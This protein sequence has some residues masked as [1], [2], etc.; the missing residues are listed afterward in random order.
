M[1]ASELP[2]RITLYGGGPGFGLPEVSPY[3][4]KT[5]VQLRMAGL[6]FTKTRADLESVPKHKM[7]YLDDDG[8]VADSTFIRAH[9]ER[10]YG[11]D[12]DRGL[13]QRQRAEA[14]AI[15]RMLED[16]LAWT[17][18]HGR[19][20]QPENF[21]KGPARFFDGA[22]EAIREKLRADVLDRVRTSFYSQGTGR[23]AQE[24]I[25]ALGARSLAALSVLLGDKPYLFGDVVTGTDATAFAV[26]AC[27]LTPFFDT[28]LR[29]EAE[30]YENL[31]AY[32]ARMMA[33]FY[34]DFAW[35]ST[36]VELAA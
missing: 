4:T 5:E 33:L 28:G 36:P 9:I 24:E 10:K 15:E 34:P 32:T 21:A 35:S 6:P 30:R 27:A 14:W 20:L 17:I 8:I 3:V 16:H 13:S 26:L 11:I 18:T 31:V 25:T 7:P 19:W 12:L 2:T 23:H 29:R 22:P 1:P